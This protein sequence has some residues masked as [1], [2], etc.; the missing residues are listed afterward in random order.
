MQVKE[1][2]RIRARNGLNKLRPGKDP[3]VIATAEKLAHQKIA[4]T[5]INDRVINHNAEEILIVKDKGKMTGLEVGQKVNLIADVSKVH[6]FDA[7]SE[8]SVL[9]PKVTVASE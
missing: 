5:L 7:E 1:I 4:N 3:F 6:I 8:V 9:Q 2:N